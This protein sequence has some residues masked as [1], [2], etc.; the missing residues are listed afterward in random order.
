MWAI[1]SSLLRH[2]RPCSPAIGCRRAGSWRDNRVLHNAEQCSKMSRE[3]AVMRLTRQPAIVDIQILRVGQLVILCVPG[4]FTT[5][6]GRRIKQAI[7]DQVLSR[8]QTLKLNT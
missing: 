4:E 8:P 7:R 2:A 3:F 5:M 6:A 1:H